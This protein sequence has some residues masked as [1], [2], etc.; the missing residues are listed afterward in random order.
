M[1]QVKPTNR[2]RQSG[3]KTG[4]RSY[5]LRLGTG[6]PCWRRF[7]PFRSVGRKASPQQE[8]PKSH[9]TVLTLSVGE[10]RGDLPSHISHAMKGDVDPCVRV[11]VLSASSLPRSGGGTEASSWVVEAKVGVE[12]HKPLD[13]CVTWPGHKVVG[14]SA[15]SWAR[16]EGTL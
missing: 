2:N 16:V 12:K 3:R 6:V 7:F 13:C 5:N 14:R 15:G 1:N 11:G 8:E 10:I 9:V 4:S